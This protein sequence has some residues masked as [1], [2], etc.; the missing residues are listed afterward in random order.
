MKDTLT[1]LKYFF[2]IGKADQRGRYIIH[3]HR[4]WLVIV[5]VFAV[6]LIIVFIVNLYFVY[7]VNKGNIFVT[8]Q[9]SVT[10]E[11][12]FNRERLAEVVSLFE[13]RE[14]QFDTLQTSR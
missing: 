14:N 12:S 13:R 9:E 8:E 6:I 11:K 7:R 4:D 5:G 3:P 10:T 1:K 2:G